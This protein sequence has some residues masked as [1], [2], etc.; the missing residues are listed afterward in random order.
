MGRCQSSLLL[1]LALCPDAD[2][3]ML[4]QHHE[5]TWSG[6]TWDSPAA[7]G[8]LDHIPCSSSNSPQHV[9]SCLPQG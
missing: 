7:K 6:D 9:D 2:R 4:A 5:Q 8:V 1:K 3:A